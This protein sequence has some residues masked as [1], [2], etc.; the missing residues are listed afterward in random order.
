MKIQR[1]IPFL[2]L[3]A[4][5][6]GGVYYINTQSI[7]PDL[8]DNGNS[9]GADTAFVRLNGELS[10]LKK[11]DSTSF[12]DWEELG[13]RILSSNAEEQFKK[14]LSSAL[15]VE[16][17][18]TWEKRFNTWTSSNFKAPPPLED[19]NK[20]RTLLANHKLL[21]L[22]LTTLQPHA[23][24]F[25]CYNTF[26]KPQAPKEISAKLKGLIKGEFKESRYSKLLNE[27]TQGS[28]AIS[29]L[30]PV[31]NAKAR[32]QAQKK[33]HKQVK[34]HYKYL[35]KNAITDLGYGKKIL[36][37]D[38][39]PKTTFTCGS[40]TWKIQDLNYYFSKGKDTSL[41]QSALW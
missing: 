6:G 32:I 20:L 25:S 24:A 37:T 11:K 22:H 23:K 18:N 12:E 10:D 35:E 31:L 17:M 13:D 8:S 28:K 15:G 34:D 19:Y 3:L 30:P 39:S 14:Q 26:F 16:A 27:L 4:L 41:W 21:S 38:I 5:L 33:C 40:R 2:L 36:P 29:S 1:L 7:D 9:V